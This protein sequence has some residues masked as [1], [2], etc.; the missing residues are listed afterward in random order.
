MI[1]DQR[2]P[3]EAVAQ[4]ASELGSV[5]PEK[6]AELASLMQ[7]S[8]AEFREGLLSG[9]ANACV[10]LQS[11]PKEAAAQYL[12]VVTAMLSADVLEARKQEAM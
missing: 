9:Y 6:Q 4:F 2:Y 11:L 5:P 3:D 8:D 12:G 10:M 7:G 1:L